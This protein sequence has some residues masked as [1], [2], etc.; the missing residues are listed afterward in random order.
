MPSANFHMSY[1]D[2]P[3]K[4]QSYWR[5][6][7]YP[8]WGPRPLPVM[9]WGSVSAQSM[10]AWQSSSASVHP[11]NAPEAWEWGWGLPGG[12]TPMGE[13]GPN[14]L[15]LPKRPSAPVSGPASQGARQPGHVSQ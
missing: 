9:G 10:A 3:H 15:L 4:P 11:W 14:R 5:G 1:H 13:H 12:S 6:L 7:R 8:G 2:I